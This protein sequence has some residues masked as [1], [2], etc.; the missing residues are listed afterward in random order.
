[1]EQGPVNQSEE[2]PIVLTVTPNQGDGDVGSFG[3]WMIAERHPRRNTRVQSAS[4]AKTPIQVR[5][6]CFN[7]VLTSDMDEEP[8]LSVGNKVVPPKTSVSSL[9]HQSQQVEATIMG[10]PPDGSKETGGQ[11]DTL[12]LPKSDSGNSF[13]AF[14][15]SSRNT[16][17]GRVPRIHGRRANSVISSLGFP[18]SHRVEANGFA[19]GILVAWYDTVSI[20]IAI[21]HFQFIHFRIINKQDRSSLLATAVYASP[22]ASG[23]KFLW[24]HLFRLASSIRGPWVLFGDFIATLCSADLQGC[25]SSARPNKAF[26]NLIFDNGLRDMRFHGPEFTWS[27]GSAFVCLDRFI[28]NSYFDEAFPVALVHHLLYM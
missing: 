22:S 4:K 3:P 13:V 2:P 14:D 1:M 27:R 19:G 20:T 26:Q 7:P 28:C 17:G 11:F 5:G 8:A 10:D 15:R 21:T 16:D 18:N 9:L 12:D 25:A 24:P 23:I 6:S